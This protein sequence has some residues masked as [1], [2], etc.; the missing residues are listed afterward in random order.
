M[1]NAKQS[2]IL[3]EPAL[4]RTS[5]SRNAAFALIG[6]TAQRGALA[7][8]L[9]MMTQ[10]RTYMRPSEA[11]R[12]SAGDVVSPSAH[13]PR[14]LE[15][16]YGLILNSTGRRGSDT[17]TTTPT[18]GKTGNYDENVIFDKP[19]EV[20]VGKV[21]ARLAKTKR[22]SESLFSL[23]Y[24]KY[25]KVF[26][27]SLDDCL[28]GEMGHTLYAWRHTG[29]STDFL[30]NRRDD[31]E[32]QAKARW[33]SDAS[34]K[35]YKKATLALK[36]GMMTDPRVCTYGELVEQNLEGFFLGTAKLPIATWM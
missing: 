6:V 26:Q 15:A 4:T 9:C 32:I 31:R 21:L 8:A 28:M 14:G 18:P 35:R 29:P 30:T 36:H 2:W 3:R 24:E 23:T 16:A 25:S 33:A 5:M 17:P 13:N 10:L 1:E 20:W 12:L 7:E 34:M 19:D 11:L 27:E 22:P